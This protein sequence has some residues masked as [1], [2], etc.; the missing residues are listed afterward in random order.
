M[1]H[2]F[3]KVTGERIVAAI[4]D[5]IIVGIISSIPPMV[6]MF[7]D[8]FDAFVNQYT[9]S[10]ISGTG[11]L[12]SYGN[13]YFI[14]SIVGGLII[15]YL[16]FAYMPYK[17]NGQTLGK[18]LMSI[19]AID[20]FG[21]NPSLKQ[22]SIRAVQIWDV[23]ASAIALPLLLVSITTYSLVSGGLSSI[24]GLLTF[25][26]FVM[27]LSKDNGQGLHDSIA[28]TYVVKSD[29]DLDKEFVEKTTQMSE[30]AEVDYNMDKEEQNKKDDW[31]E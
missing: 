6:F 8:G 25:V 2:K 10:I 9:E 11:D 23:Y 16:Y 4:I 5:S 1:E 20:E 19:K 7:K 22:H 30:W 3:K 29:I 13:M 14:V 15:G 27:I 21:N 26:A 17:M 12:S 31:Y 28:G 24:A 18:K